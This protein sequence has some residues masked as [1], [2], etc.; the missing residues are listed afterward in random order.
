MSDVD[1][2]VDQA[3]DHSVDRTADQTAGHTVDLTMATRA[4]FIHTKY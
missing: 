4:D 3:A 1:D 2:T